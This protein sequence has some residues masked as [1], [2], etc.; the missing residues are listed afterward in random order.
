MMRGN[1]SDDV[2]SVRFYRRIADMSIPDLADESG[3]TERE[4]E[5]I[6]NAPP[7]EVL[8]TREG[9]AEAIAKVLKTSVED[10]FGSTP[11]IS[12]EF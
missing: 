12:A 9:V 1:M 4:I 2:T 7:D 11:H 3:V 5:R 10:L 8:I 6:E